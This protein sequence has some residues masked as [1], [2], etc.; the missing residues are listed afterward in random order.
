[1]TEVNDS[2]NKKLLSFTF[3]VHYF[4]LADITHIHYLEDIHNGLAVVLY[5]PIRGLSHRKFIRKRWLNRDLFRRMDFK[6][7]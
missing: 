7:K 1:M 4:V 5:L 3:T 2:K 6:L